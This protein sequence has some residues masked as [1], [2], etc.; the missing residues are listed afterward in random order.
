MTHQ[1]IVVT[2]VSSIAAAKELGM[3]E[4]DLLQLAKDEEVLIDANDPVHSQVF[5]I[6]PFYLPQGWLE[7]VK[8]RAQPAKEQP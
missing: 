7:A 5:G 3:G 1:P 6:S 4:A 2:I 8:G